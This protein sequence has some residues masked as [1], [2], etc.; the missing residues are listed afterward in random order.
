M[1]K[2]SVTVSDPWS[3][4]YEHGSNLTATVRGTDGEF[5]L[6][7]LAGMLYVASPRG[8]G[9]YSLVPTTEDEAREAPLWGRN[10][11]RGQPAALLADLTL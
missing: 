4:T 10:L 9:A 5:L 2:V 1:R 8:E 11:W 6:L 3:F 7:E